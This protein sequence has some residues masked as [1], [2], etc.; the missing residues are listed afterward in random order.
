[1]LMKSFGVSWSPLF[2]VAPDEVPEYELPV[3]AVPADELPVDEAPEVVLYAGD[4]LVAAG[5]GV[6]ATVE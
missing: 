2:V 1:M 3:D 6:G 5:M 4:V